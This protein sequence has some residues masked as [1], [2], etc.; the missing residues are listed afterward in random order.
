[1]KFKMNRTKY[2]I[3]IFTILGISGLLYASSFL[4]YGVA[5]NQSNGNKCRFTKE[6]IL[7]VTG[8]TKL[9]KG[10]SRIT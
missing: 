5:Q 7:D 2:A 10:K 1:M 4:Q 9:D 6:T 8:S 3:A